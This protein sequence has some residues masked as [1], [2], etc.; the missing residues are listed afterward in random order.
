MASE[1]NKPEME[2]WRGQITN[3]P[4]WKYLDRK[5]EKIKCRQSKEGAESQ[6]REMS[7][8]TWSRRILVTYFPITGRKDPG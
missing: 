3:R 6:G 7:G 1:S 8:A 5:R 4:V 2:A